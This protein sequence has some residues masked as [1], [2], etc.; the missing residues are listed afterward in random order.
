MESAEKKSIMFTLGTR[1]EAIKL[2]PVIRAFQAD[3]AFQTYLCVTAQ[4]RELLDGVLA[5]FELR[6]DVDLGLMR[7]GQSLATLT[8]RIVVACEEVF[9]SFRPDLMFVQGDTTTAFAAAVAASQ[10]QIPVAHVE[11]GL[12]SH[13]KRS[14]FPEEINRVM[15][16]HLAELHFA[17]GKTAVENLRREGITHGVHLVGNPV[18]DAL[19]LARSTLA[20]RHEPARA[21]RQLGLDP[22][23]KIVLVTLHRRESFGQP[24]EDTCAAIRA[25][26]ERCTDAEIL[27]PVHLN[28]NVHGTIHRTLSG[29]KNVHLLEPLDYADF[30]ALLCRASLIISDSGGVLEEAETLGLPVLVT[31][32]VTERVEALAGGNVRLVGSDKHQIFTEA[33]A[34]L[35]AAP[36]VNTTP[37]LRRTFGDGHAS[38]RILRFTREYFSTPLVRPSLGSPTALAFPT[39]A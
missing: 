6:P 39:A 20:Q 8:S 30:V 18:V 25:V 34:L 36:A 17:P 12:R 28:P 27:C 4:H 7:P 32:E 21:I 10:C 1:P 19:Q 38:T 37:T 2:A 11:A 9:A 16:G 14:P 24:L 23:R 13:R 35:G 15:I 5:F 22:A 29:L 33:M 3:P 26:A 31:R